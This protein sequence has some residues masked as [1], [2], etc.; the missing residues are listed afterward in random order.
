METQGSVKRSPVG[1][2]YELSTELGRG[3]T[4]TVWEARDRT[5]D[6]L[7]AVKILH[8]SVLA[9]NL[10]RRRFLREVELA[11]TLRHPHCVELLGH[12]ED[13]EGRAYL[14]MERLFG[15]TLAARLRERK[16]LPP[17]EAIGLCAQVLDA[18]GAAHAVR[19]VHRDLKPANV[20]LIDTDDRRDVVKVCDFGL[21]KAIDLDTLREPGAEEE[22]GLSAISTELGD[23]CGT[24]EYMAPEQ[25][26][27]EEIDGRAD[28]YSAGIILY[29]ALVGRPPFQARS[30][31]AVVS[32]HLTAPPP[33]PSALRPDLD[34]YPPLENL[35]LRALSKD[36]A[37]RP[38][39]AAVFGADLRQIGRDYARRNRG[40]PPVA[41]AD[42]RASVTLA[43]APRPGRR[44]RAAA[45]AIGVAAAAATA[46]IA[47]G[48]RLASRAAPAAPA[49]AARVS[50]VAP[51][52]VA[53]ARPPTPGVASPVTR[54]EAPVIPVERHQVPSPRP[55]AS[56]SARRAR[57]TVPAPSAPP[58]V[59]ATVTLAA[60][61]ERL[62]AGR[63]A[64]ACALGQA[65]ADAHPESPTAWRFLGRCRM[66]LGQRGQAAAAFRRYLELAPAGDDA[67][68]V[69]AILEENP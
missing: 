32:M 55:D 63:I 49:V 69:R 46:A 56:T 60:A 13:D 45:I 12:G 42:G 65:V 11:G 28:L 19:I 37:E 2:R 5:S 22:I 30:P 66:R 14:V 38:S 58:E 15:T 62:G 68:F 23:I 34:I 44:W 10:G 51:A 61:E 36:P 3:A 39:S 21:A 47:G 52:A 57:R 4:G 18:V 25:A 33:R 54:I 7:V 6:R 40:Q 64:E 17:L 48:R 53:T 59:Q 27:G 29:H 43:G 41:S 35:I 9:S 16:V 50:E 26:R 67:P 24:P 20:M 8:P 1:D 31:L